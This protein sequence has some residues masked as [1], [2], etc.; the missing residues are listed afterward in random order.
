[1]QEVADIL[2]RIKPK[3]SK[4]RYINASDKFTKSVEVISRL[5]RTFF[6]TIK[7]QQEQVFRRTKKIKIYKRPQTLDIGVI[8]NI[9]DIGSEQQI[10]LLCIM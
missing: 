9:G 7:Y 4:K 10:K 6:L 5:I 1:M 3:A 8:G 2:I